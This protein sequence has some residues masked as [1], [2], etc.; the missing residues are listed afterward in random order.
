[1]QHPNQQPQS[2]YGNFASIQ[3]HLERLD[4]RLDERTRD[5]ATRQDL[6]ALRREVVTRDLLE[7]Q[8]NLLRADMTRLQTDQANDRKE[9][10]KQFSEN[11]AEQT[12]RSER[13]WI[14]LSP[15]IAAIALLLAVIQFLTQH[16]HFTP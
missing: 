5:L 2:E 8:L 11:K 6:E 13:F 7:S 1:M 14:R 3:R 4:E 12:S 16:I 9:I 10:E 15:L